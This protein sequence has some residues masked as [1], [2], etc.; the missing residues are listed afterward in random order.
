MNKCNLCGSKDFQFL[1]EAKDMLNYSKETFKLYKC[2]KCG[3]V[4][5][6]PQPDVS[7][8]YPKEYYSFDIK[9]S[10]INETLHKL[11]YKSIIT[12]V[13]LKPLRKLL[14]F[15][16]LKAKKGR[17]LD[18]GSGSGEFLI[19][20]KQL[21][22]KCYGIEPGKFNKEFT[23][24]NKLEIKNYQLE[25]AKYPD[26]FFDIITMRHSLEHVQDPLK[27]LK[28]A[29]RILKPKGEVII[30]IPN[31]DSTM[32]KR[33]GKYWV[34]LDVPRHLFN[35][36]EKTIEKYAKKVGF[37]IKRMKTFTY[38]YSLLTSMGYKKGRKGVVR[39]KLLNLIA[40]PI[41]S[42]IDI[43]GKGDVIEII[44]EK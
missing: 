7:K 8:Y 34:N 42:L 19:I 44:L 12:R 23:E 28:E 1:F 4:F 18:I 13:L 36:S 30:E 5:I 43:V 29:K 26:N 20:M 39:N 10:K 25:N 11:Y 16:D 38:P 22:M 15:R 41:T 32:Y 33:F 40:L 2:K 21:G 35:F 31:I 9:R 37:K 17:I 27:T 14:K 24:K 3:L 6:N